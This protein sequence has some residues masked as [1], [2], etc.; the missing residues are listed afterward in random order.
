M[1]VLKPIELKLDV[2][3]PIQNCEEGLPLSP[4]A[5]LCHQP[6]SRIYIIVMIGMKTKMNPEVIKA[7]LVHIFLK[8]PRFCSLQVEDETV[9]GGLKWVNQKEVNLDNHVIVPNLDINN[10]ES[11]D[12]FVED[13]VS[14]LSKTG[15]KMSM[16]MWDIH[17]LNLKTTDAESVA[18][19]RVHHSLG[20]GISLMSLFLACTR[21]ISS[22]NEP[23]TIPMVKKVNPSKSSRGFWGKFIKLWLVILLF[24][25]TLVDVSMF[26]ATSLSLLNDTKTPLKGPL[27]QTRRFVRRSV[28]LDDVKLVKNTMNTTINDV[29]QAVTQA[30]LS[31]YL[32]RKYG[33]LELDV[34]MKKGSKARWGNKMGY[35]FY[36]FTI[37]LRDDPI[38]CLREAKATMDRKKASLEASFSYFSPKCF[39]KF[40]GVKGQKKKS[41]FWAIQWPIL[42]QVAM[43]H[44]PYANKITFILSVD[45]GIIPDPNQLCDDL[46]ESFSLIKSAAIAKGM[47]TN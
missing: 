26:I 24:W 2:E 22:P 13:Y 28:S 35:L 39:I 11:P 8:Q 36:P 17:L 3:D 15:I 14:N 10:I 12:K 38:D 6:D 18:V 30:G 23:P 4:I 41:V 9:K 27:S 7:S 43:G 47:P 44:P 25:N 5:R 21:K 37:A 16:P 32:N 1:E 20:D 45:E 40:G 46:E 19:F 34:M 29:M 42:L 31:R 33:V